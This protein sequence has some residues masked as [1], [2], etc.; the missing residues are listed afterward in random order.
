MEEIATS[1]RSGNLEGGWQ[2]APDQGLESNLF[3]QVRVLLWQ[4]VG[5][6]HRMSMQ[7]KGSLVNLFVN[8]GQAQDGASV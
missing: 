8:Q 7:F 1:S 5:I 4:F 2:P 3:F 6:M